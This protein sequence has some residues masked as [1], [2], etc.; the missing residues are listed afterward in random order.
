MWALVEGHNEDELDRAL[1]T[2]RKI[3]GVNSRNLKTLEVDSKVFANVLPKI[4]VEIFTVAESGISSR[5]DV[6]YAKLH[7]A[8]AVLIGEAL[9]RGNEPGATLR[10]LIGQG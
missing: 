9:V 10:A 6:E 8:Q 7:G 5:A 2:G 1:T 3:I 4:P